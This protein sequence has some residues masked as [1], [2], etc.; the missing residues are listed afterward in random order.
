M[1]PAASE[2]MT[3]AEAALAYHERTRHGLQRHAAGPETLDWDMQPNPFREF[4]GTPRLALPLGVRALGT[5]FAA[6]YAWA[7]AALQPPSIASLGMLLQLSLGISAWKEYGPDR[8]ALRC[9]PS[10]GNLHPTEAYV[11]S[12][13]LPGLADGLYH[14]LS[15][16]HALEQRCRSAADRGAAGPPWDVWSFAP[17]IHS[18]FFAHRVAGL[19][20]GLYALSRHPESAQGLREALRPDFAWQSVDG[21]PAHLPF[22]K[23]QVADC[24]AAARTVSCHQA[25]ASDGCFSLAMLGALAPIVRQNPWRYRQL[26]WEAGLIGHVLYLEAEAAGLRGT[27]IGCYFDDAL[28]GLIRIK[29][30]GLQSLY[31]FTVGRPLTDDRIATLPAYPDRQPQEPEE[32]AS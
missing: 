28:H 23:L 27:G 1:R 5:S 32:E 12:R 6:L 3:A 29:A 20:P 8:R 19:E 25:I 10:S 31:H 4:A 17:S 2:A 21:A 18:V 16:D 13:N 30:G 9:N 24:R 14:Y 15:R 7:D 11:L 22:F 26:H